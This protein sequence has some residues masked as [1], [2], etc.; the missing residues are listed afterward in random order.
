MPRRRRLKYRPKPGKPG[1]AGGDFVSPIDGTI[2]SRNAEMDQTVAA[3]SE[4]LPLFVI[5][6]D[7]TLTHIDA[8]VSGRNIGEVT[9]GDKASFSVASFPN[10]PFAG[11]VT[12]IRAVRSRCRR[13]LSA[14]FCGK[15]IYQPAGAEPASRHRSRRAMLRSF[16]KASV[17]A[18]L[19]HVPFVCARIALSAIRS[20][21]V[22][23]MST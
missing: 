18:S 19:D 1:C 20:R 9:L 17:F 3:D 15:E 10:H 6:A 22:F 21:A 4:T 16:L 5:A 13:L 8:S 14:P 2:V 7:L 11:E 12:K 23:F